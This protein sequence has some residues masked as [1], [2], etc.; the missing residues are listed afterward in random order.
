MDT[1]PNARVERERRF[2]LG[3][4]PMDAAELPRRQITDRYLTA[5]RLRLRL[6][7]HADGA[8]EYQLTQK[9]PWGRPGPVRGL[10]TTMDLGVEEYELLAGLPGTTLAKLRLS[11]PALV[12]DLYDPPLDGLVV[13]EAEFGTDE[14]ARDFIP[15]PECL[16]EVTD[17]PRFTGGLLAHTRRE[18]LLA[19]LAEYGIDPHRHRPARHLG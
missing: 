2:L 18:D 9:L 6:V 13:A 3:R 4:A 19:W 17:D 8:R 16:R 10:I 12:I 15:P 1:G 7:E 14:Q 11:R 5:T